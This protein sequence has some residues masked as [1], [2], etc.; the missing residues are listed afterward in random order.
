MSWS[1]ENEAVSLQDTSDH[2]HLVECSVISN[3]KL[4]NADECQQSFKSFRKTIHPRLKWNRMV[5]E[6]S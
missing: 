3:K 6:G 5:D 4:V 1:L 2:R